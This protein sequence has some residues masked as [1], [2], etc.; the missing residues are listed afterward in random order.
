ME[1][2]ILK[3][4][5]IKTKNYCPN[6]IARH[7]IPAYADA[8]SN[9]KV[10]GTPAYNSW[11]KEQ[12]HYILNGYETGG[13]WL[14]GR[15][16]KFVNFDTI[17]GVAGDNMRAELHDF[18]LDYAYLIE[19]AKQEHF[20]I[21]VPKARRKTVT[22]MNV[23]M[24]IDYGYRF[25]SGYKAGIIAGQ[26][27]FAKSFYEEWMYT[28]SHQFP[29]FRIKRLS[30]GEDT[31]AGYK[32][33]TDEGKI[34][35]GSLNSIYT[36]TVFHD[37][38]VMK[39][40]FLNDAVL[41]ESG[42]NE[43]TVE[44]LNATADCFMRGDVQ[45]GIAHIYGTGGNMNKGSKGFKQIYMDCIRAKAH[46]MGKPK[47]NPDLG[48]TTMVATNRGGF[49]CEG[50]FI[51]A[52]VFYYPYYAG[53][54][55]PSGRLVE[56]IPNLQHLKPHERVGWSDEE[57][58]RQAIEEK[59]S[60]LLSIGNMK[61]YHDYCQNNPTT[62]KEVFR[63]SSTNNFNIIA[64]NDQGFKIE[65]EELKF[66]RYFLEYKK[67]ES[68]GEYITP[69][70][71]EAKP[72]TEATPEHEIVHILFDGHP[73]KGYRWLDV[74]GIDS[75]DQDQT[76]T[77]KSLGSM[78]VMRGKH[79]IPG[80]PSWAPVALIR[81]RPPRKEMFYELCMKL[82]IYYNL[83]GSVLGDVRS[84]LIIQYFKDNGCER[85]LSKRPLKFESPHSKQVNEYWVSLNT[86]SKPRMIGAL[87]TLFD[88]HANKIW[89]YPLIDEALNYDEFETSEDSDNDS[90]D[91]L[92][93]A[94]MKLLDQTHVAVN[95][96]DLLQKNPYQYPVWGEN[97]KGDIIDRTFLSHVS[98]D[99]P[100]GKNEDYISRYYRMIVA[101]NN[102]E[103]DVNKD[104]YW[105]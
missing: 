61:Q 19:Q 87:Q 66:G 44:C 42:E 92:G 54:T 56:D 67:D 72:A 29:E 96:E 38:N 53:A 60:K 104:P 103:D 81:N 21:I 85:Y 26:E 7:G 28:D 86:F 40:K 6:P 25:E 14:P 69:L 47:Y 68:T 105:K 36:R 88:F 18:Q 27:K 20:N 12:V 50:H 45:Y 5:L 23:G 93:I 59:K 39:G 37:P 52:T 22:T 8:R 75:Y 79:N 57:R 33:D 46:D 94:L 17:R 30:K 4:G 101:Q 43:H 34:D 32:I 9:P 83:I 98:K 55:D 99:E 80:T 73:V 64:L 78:V 24:V 51:P 2:A 31:I 100:I 41:E 70:E 89:F 63:K 97:A 16:Y 102:E 15:Y 74:A 58:A 84:G 3:G 1:F 13:I 62:I 91:A 10:K 11:W 35:S 95:E 65:S 71:V 82:S 76:L 48:K 77:T 49:N 90:V